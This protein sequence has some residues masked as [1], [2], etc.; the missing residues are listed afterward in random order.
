MQ[1]NL[2]RAV[3]DNLSATD[4]MIAGVQDGERIAA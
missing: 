4:E 1:P 3:M 2:S